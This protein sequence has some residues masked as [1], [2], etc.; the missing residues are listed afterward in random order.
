MIRNRLKTSASILGVVWFSLIGAC[1]ALSETR[2]D[3]PAPQEIN[4]KPSVLATLAKA[5]STAGDEEQRAFARIALVQMT[6]AYEA[7][8]D[9]AGEAAP[10]TPAA[11]KKLTRWRFATR[12][13][14]TEFQEMSRALESGAPLRLHVDQQHR[15]LMFVGDHPMIV[16][17]PRIG[18]KEALEQRIRD[19]FCVAYECEPLLAEE[20][21][22]E[23]PEPEL[24]PG[25]TWAL[26]HNRRPRYETVD[27]LLFEFR[28]MSDRGRK[29]QACLAVIP[30]LRELAKALRKAREARYAIDWAG[31]AIEALPASED[32]QVILNTQGD[33]LRLTLPRLEKAEQVWREAL[34]WLRAR[35]DGKNYRMRFRNSERLLPMAT[36]GRH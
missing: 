20:K 19:E 5:V 29:E 31:L 17:G 28:N 36:A 12:R 26:G 34:P 21:R 9:R 8:L 33:Y 7:E 11:R 22:S 32:H 15:V 2:F 3:G 6:A 13:F 4:F 18:K 24:P 14:L 1:D 23:P 10:K 27:G 30:E 35:S 25:G 16:N